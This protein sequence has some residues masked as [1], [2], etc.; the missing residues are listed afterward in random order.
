MNGLVA[1]TTNPTCQENK[2]QSKQEKNK[3]NTASIVTP[4]VSVVRPFIDVISSVKMLVRLPVD[5][6]SNHPMFLFSMAL[7][8]LT[9]SLYVRF[10]PLIAKLNF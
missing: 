5:L 8:S 7:N 9:L 6:F 4:S 1:H 10:S 2:K 3:P